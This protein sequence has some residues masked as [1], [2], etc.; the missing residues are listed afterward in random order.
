MTYAV[1]NTANTDTFAYWKTRTNELA[2]AMST[3][4][5]TADSN[6]VTGNINFNGI[7]SA[8]TIAVKTALRGGNVTTSEVLVITS[9]VSFTT[10]GSRITFGNSTVNAVSNS[11]ILNLNDTVHNAVL[12]TTKLALTN[13]TA[14]INIVIPTAAEVSG[15]NYY[16]NANGSYSKPVED[17]VSTNTVTTG[18]SA[19]LID[20]FLKASYRSG[21]YTITIKDNAA[22]AHQTTKLLVLHNNSNT[23]AFYTEYAAV[24]SNTE[25]G[26]MSANANSTHVLVYITPTVA[27]STVSLVKTLLTA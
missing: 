5:I 14:N 9:N 10:V 18:T 22:N 20:N 12:S 19:Q 24:F 7:F 2:H 8:N 26:L 25:L 4:V 11:I 17:S 6:S 21:E 1:A 15:G 13:S 27:N 3:Y 23:D 16:L